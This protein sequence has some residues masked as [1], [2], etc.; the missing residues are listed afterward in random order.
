[1]ELEEEREELPADDEERP[2]R[3]HEPGYGGPRQEHRAWQAGNRLDGPRHL[4]RELRRAIQEPGPGD[5]ERERLDCAAE[6][7]ERTTEAP[8]LDVGDP[9]RRPARRLELAHER[10]EC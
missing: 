5:C 1:L 4:L 10:A 9:L 7:Q 2:D 3:R 6:L 8:H